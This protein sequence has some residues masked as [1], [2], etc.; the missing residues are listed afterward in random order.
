MFCEVTKLNTDKELVASQLPISTF[1]LHLQWIFQGVT[2][3]TLEWGAEQSEDV[4]LLHGASN[5]CM[6]TRMSDGVAYI[7]ALD[8]D[9]GWCWLL[10]VRGAKPKWQLGGVA[11]GPV[12][13]GVG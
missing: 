5:C 3:A 13:W 6:W 2:G 12:G 1:Q 4:G 8:Q 10:A 11:V 9:G 7:L